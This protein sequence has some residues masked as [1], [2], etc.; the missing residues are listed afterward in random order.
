MYK[1]HKHMLTIREKRTGLI[2][3]LIRGLKDVRLLSAEEGMLKKT[4]QRLL[5]VNEE[6]KDMLNVG[7]KYRL[8]SGN[9]RD[10][11]DVLFLVLGT[12]LVSFQKLT[13]PNF[14]VLFMY[15]GRVESLLEFYNDLAELLKNYNLSATRV[16]EVLTDAYE[17]EVSGKEIL[18]EIKGH[19]KLENVSFAYDK[20][21]VLKNVSFEI[22]PGERVGFVGESG[23]GKS[24]IFSLLTKLYTIEE[25]K[26]L[27]D[28]ID[29]KD[30][31][32][33]SLRKNV[34]LI[35]QSPYIFNFSIKDNLLLADNK[36]TDNQLIEAVKKA[37]LYDRILEFE[38][39]F[40]TEVGEG[41]VTLSGGERQRLA[42]ARSL[43]K[44]SNII[45]FD[46]ATSALDNITQDKVQKAIYG[47]DKEKTILII[48]HR[49]STIINC[50]KIIVLDDGKVIDI[51]PH[52]E[53][54]KRCKKY[55]ELYQFEQKQ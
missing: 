10:L 29:I 2:S 28:G 32:N 12:I 8:L 21:E 25:G 31:E 51:G 26:I 4:K 37:E 5:S 33:H 40:E 23:S 44:K 41:G 35:P 15:R 19:I 55:Q 17:K 18:K 54:L 24:T 47:L 38:N 53:L 3:E 1:R 11:S 42:I 43:L 36:A 7:T 30:I 45:L 34:S 6:R 22:K 20:E 14:V 52:E 39:G 48:A 16:F 9:I 49:L 46:E 27:I 13:G 50:D